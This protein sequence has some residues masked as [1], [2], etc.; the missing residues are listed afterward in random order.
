MYAPLTADSCGIFQQQGQDL[1]LPRSRR[2]SLRV[3]VM[4]N[5]PLQ[6]LLHDLLLSGFGRQ[7]GA[8]PP[9]LIPLLA[10]CPLLPG[11]WPPPRTLAS[12]T[13]SFNN[14][15]RTS[16][17]SRFADNASVCVSFFNK[18]HLRQCPS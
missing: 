5:A 8:T 15:I 14:P 16:D 10:T 2:G 7:G 13:A 9:S 11:A 18:P 17:S 4:T 1:V 3:I 6:E 12:Q